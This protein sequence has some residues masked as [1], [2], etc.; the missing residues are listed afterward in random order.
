VKAV[1][2]I[3]ALLFLGALAVVLVQPIL[4]A[5]EEPGRRERQKLTDGDDGVAVSSDDE[6]VRVTARYPKRCM[7]KA[8]G[9]G[10]G[11]VAARRGSVAEVGFPAQRPVARIDVSGDV[12]WSPS[13]TFLAER[14][15]R[16][17]DQSGNP[18]GALFFEPRKWQWSPV[19]D[20]ALATTDR[21]SLTFSIPDTTRKGIRLLNA[22]VADFDLS[23]NGRRLAAVIEGRGLFVADLRRGRAVQATEGR[24][25]L[26]G[27]FSNRS[28]L[29]SKSE[30]SGKLRFA[31]GS[32][33]TTIVRG[34]FAGGTLVRCGGRAL[35][36]SAVKEANPALVEL[37]S[38]GGGMR[39]D[40]LE[41]PPAR[42]DGYSGAACSPDGQLIAASAIARGGLKGPLLLLGSDGTFVRELVP[43]RTAN[44]TWS[45][46]GLMFT[47]FGK[48]GRGRLWLIAPGAD[49]APTAYRVGAPTQY[50]WH[51]R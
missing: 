27:W 43:G 46:D 16:V 30:G 35:L 47:K 17:F 5:E 22:P 29:Y 33:K 51:V 11:L 23:P 28:V 21:G 13:G 36:V 40:V 4:G 1:K 26:V 32:G 19:A 3:A 39:Q 18:Q 12:A 24:A 8:R 44:P 38:L 15:G 14:G 41:P 25:A 37:V 2:T 42:Y 9:P 50:D 31:I 6:R 49:P 34:A 10:S 45:R 20:C 7:R 48:A